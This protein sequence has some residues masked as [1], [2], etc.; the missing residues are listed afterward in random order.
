MV[1]YDTTLLI[2]TNIRMSRSLMG[3]EN[4][5]FGISVHVFNC[6]RLRLHEFNLHTFVDPSMRLESLDVRC[7]DSQCHLNDTC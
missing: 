6:V 1:F 4:S 2:G 7:P 5:A 3:Q